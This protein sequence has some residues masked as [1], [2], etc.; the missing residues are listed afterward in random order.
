[1]GESLKDPRTGRGFRLHLPDQA[2]HRR[3]LVLVLNL[4]GKGSFPRWQDD[5][6][7]AYCLANQYGLVVATPEMGKEQ[8]TTGPVPAGADRHLHNIVDA[9]L[10]RFGPGRFSSFWLAGHSRGSL[11]CYR[12][13]RTTSLAEKV[14]GWLSL[15]GGRLGWP[16]AGAAGDGPVR[17]AHVE[18]R[19]PAPTRQLA[20]PE[21]DLSFI[22]A[23]GG[24][25]LRSLPERS[26]LAE[27]YA[28]GPRRRLADV[29]DD[30]PG[31]AYDYSGARPTPEWGGRPRPGT[32]HVYVYPAARDGRVIADIVRVGKGHTE[33][34]EPKITEAIVRLMVSAPA[35]KLGRPQRREDRVK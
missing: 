16:D 34:L 10:D 21:A 14:D 8:L 22:Y 26:P 1:M 3:S 27:R 29:V 24:H 12:L 18:P 5:Y 7:P 33:G 19:G 13:L 28:A 15:S 11:A 35:G 30:K 20:P 25:E 23:V 32:A 31:R 9:L 4:H 17:A 2:E 6:F